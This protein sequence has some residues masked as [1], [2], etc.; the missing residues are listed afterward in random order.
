MLQNHPPAVYHRN[1]NV[2]LMLMEINPNSN[3]NSSLKKSGPAKTTSLYKNV[4]NMKV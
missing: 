2:K 3:L 4:A 1:I